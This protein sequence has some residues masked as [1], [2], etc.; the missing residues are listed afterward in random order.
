MDA[1]NHPISRI[2]ELPEAEQRA[3]KDA[4]AELLD[5]GS[6]LGFEPRNRD[7]YQRAAG[8]WFEP[9]QSTLALLDMELVNDDERLVLQARPLDTCALQ[10][11][12]DQTES[13]FVL[14]LWKVYD[15][16]RQSGRAGVVILSLDDFFAKLKSYLPNLLQTP[17]KQGTY[18]RVLAALQRRNL[19]RYSWNEISPGQSELQVLPTILY[20]MPFAGLEAWVVQMDKFV[21]AAAPDKTENPISDEL[22][23]S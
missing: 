2:A 5:R 15:E 22:Q 13:L 7:L 1:T 8:S 19:V 17:P 9:L 12:F 10:R 11:R 16:Y 4:L 18:N 14:A 20:V 3:F 23:Q 6:L 21:E